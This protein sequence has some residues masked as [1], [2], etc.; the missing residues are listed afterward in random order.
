MAEDWKDKLK[1]ILDNQ[2]GYTP[3][4]V[5]CDENK[6]LK[7]ISKKECLTLFYERKGR[8]GKQAT[9]ISGFDADEKEISSV[10]AH[11]KKALG[12]GGSWRGGEILIQGDRRSDVRKILSEMGYK[13]KN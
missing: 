3:E 9:L 7:S 1:T 4:G 10:A 2:G 11:L 5:S 13:I 6:E 8:A 12:T